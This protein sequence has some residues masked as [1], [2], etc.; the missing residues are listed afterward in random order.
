MLKVLEI[1]PVVTAV[2]YGADD[3]IGAV[4]ALDF[5]AIMGH[6][7]DVML[8]GVEIVDLGEEKCPFDLVF[9]KSD[10]GVGVTS[11]DNDAFA[12]SA[13]AAAL[14]ADVHQFVGTDYINLP[15]A[16]VTAEIG[17]KTMERPLVGSEPGKIWLAMVVRTDTPDFAVG[18]LRLRFAFEPM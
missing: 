7:R 3:Q 10:P 1:V 12:M 5:Q 13:A 6:P 17:A 16:T 8:R 2:Q 14:V 4:M 9:F 18:D 11:G 15:S